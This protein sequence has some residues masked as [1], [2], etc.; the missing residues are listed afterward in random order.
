MRQTMYIH[1][2]S[3]SVDFFSEF[4]N[5]PFAE[6]EY[7]FIQPDEKETWDQNHEQ[8]RKYG[9]NE[10]NVKYT[11]NQSGYRGKNP[12]GDAGFGCSYSFGYGVD[13]THTWPYMLDIFNG[14]LP[15]SSNDRIARLAVQYMNT[16]RP[17]NIYIVWSFVSRREHISDDKQFFQFTSIENIQKAKLP[18]N[19]YKLALLELSN[20]NS[21]MLNLQKNQLLVEYIAK[22]LNINYKFM[23]LQQTDYRN[24]LTS[25]DLDHPNRDWHKIVSQEI[26]K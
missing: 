26:V 24:Y 23:L 2:P 18:G 19:E 14:A 6:G 4:E 21:D 12:G 20:K 22:S 3:K 25:R 1:R 7:K 15:G 5:G 11:I 16:Y 17:K 8:S 9:W 13:D 10:D